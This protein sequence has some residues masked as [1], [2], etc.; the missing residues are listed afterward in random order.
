MGQINNKFLHGW[1]HKYIGH[2]PHP[3]IATLMSL[4]SNIF[5]NE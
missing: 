4:Q 2:K 1:S 3:R 5:I